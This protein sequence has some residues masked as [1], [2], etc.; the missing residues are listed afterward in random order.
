MH[1]RCAAEPVMG[2]LEKPRGRRT[3][4]EH[5]LRVGK[6]A[7]HRA[8]QKRNRS[9]GF[10]AAGYTSGPALPPGRN[11]RVRQPIINDLGS[12]RDNRQNGRHV[13]RPTGSRWRP[14]RSQAGICRCPSRPAHLRAD[15]SALPNHNVSTHTLRG[16]LGRRFGV[17]LIVRGWSGRRLADSRSI[18]SPWIAVEHEAERIGARIVGGKL[19]VDLLGIEA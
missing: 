16:A 15:L 12:R 7:K 2:Y 17:S 11:K 10:E 13:S 3:W 18:G 6:R 5:R 19:A 1:R 4:D 8:V 14:Y 9:R